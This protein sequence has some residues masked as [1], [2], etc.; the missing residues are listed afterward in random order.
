ME[1]VNKITNRETSNKINI[2]KPNPFKNNFKILKYHSL[3]VNYLSKLND[4][5]LISCGDDC[6]LNIYK[7]DSYELQL[8]IKEH[9]DGILSFIQLKDGRI[10]TCSYDAT[11]KII[12]LIGED[13]YQIDQTLN[14]EITI[15]SVIEIKENELIS[16]SLDSTMKI[17]KL[18]N[19]FK[20]ESILNIKFRKYDHQACNILKLN[21]NEFV[22]SL[23]ADKSLKF[24]NLNNFSN[25]ATINNIETPGTAQTMCL[26]EDDVLCV[27]SAYNYKGF[28]LIKISTHQI[29]KNIIGPKTIYAISKCLNGSLLCSIYFEEG[30]DCLVKYKYKD[31]NLTIIVEKKKAHNENI[32][33]CIEFNDGTIA[34]GGADNLIKL[35]RD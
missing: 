4:G 23:Y 27:G 17:W 10:I 18:N 11:M 2:Y 7:K 31:Q 24:W 22:I 13:K 15:Y 26:L 21:K 14:H 1:K 30:N 20:F 19:Q 5:R 16:V 6:L 35:W 29:I 8:S 12:K 3:C 34:S 32:Y 25:I 9:S 33:T 28:Y